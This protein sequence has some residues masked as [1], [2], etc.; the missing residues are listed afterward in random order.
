MTTRR[1]LVPAAA[2]A[3][4]LSSLLPATLPL[5]AA[6]QTPAPPAAQSGEQPTLNDDREA[7]EAAQK[8]LALIDAGRSGDAWDVAAPFLKSAVTRPKWIAGMRDAR[9]P[10]GKFVSRNATRFA[11]AHSIPGAPDGDYVIVEFETVFA[12]GKRATE[13]LTWMIEGGDQWRVAGYYIR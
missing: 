10:F 7:I 2:F 11:R 4:W 3:A 6:G 12:N 1:V 13:H 5:P 9:K 8:W